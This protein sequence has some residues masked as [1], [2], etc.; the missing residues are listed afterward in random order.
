M[1]LFNNKYKIESTRLENWDY[2]NSGIYLITICTKFGQHFFGEVVDGVMHLN[3]MGKIVE[4]FWTEIPNRTRSVL[5][6]IHQVMPDHFHGLILLKPPVTIPLPSGLIDRPYVKKIATAAN[7]NLMNWGNRFWDSR[8]KK[9]IESEKENNLLIQSLSN[10]YESYNRKPIFAKNQ[11]MSDI[12]P[13]SGSLSV[14]LRTFKSASKKYINKNIENA[15]FDWHPGFHDRIIRDYPEFI[16]KE[17][18]IINNPKNW[19]KK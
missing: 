12:S 3:E 17:K 16:R 13:K 5:L 19:K 8:S 15:N 2:R 18:Y 10:N 7:G 14:I 9:N 4:R 1:A 6:G 11:F